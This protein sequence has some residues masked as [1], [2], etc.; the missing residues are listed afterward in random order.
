M[1]LVDGNDPSTSFSHKY[2]SLPLLPDGS[3]LTETCL[4]Q[5]LNLCL[6]RKGKVDVIDLVWR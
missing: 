6:Y 5:K 2:G 4:G 3:N 1:G